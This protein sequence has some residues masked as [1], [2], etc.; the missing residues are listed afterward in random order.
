MDYL[1]E[2]EEIVGQLRKARQPED[3]FGELKG[4]TEEMLAQG[5]RIYRKMAQQVHPDTRPGIGDDDLANEGFALL[6]KLWGVAQI[7]IQAGMYGR[8]GEP[9]VITTRKRE[10]TVLDVLEKGDLC[11]LY[12]CTFPV[13][14]HKVKGVFKVARESSDNDLVNNEAD[15][16]KYLF[17]ADSERKFGAYLPHLIETFHYRDSDMSGSRVVNVLAYDDEISSP[18]ALYS[19]KQVRQHCRDGIDPRDMAWMWRRT[20][21]VL[22]FAHQQQV[23]H[24]AVLPTHI[25][26]QPE[27]HGL[28]LI[29]WAY[30][31]QDPQ[32]TGRHIR[33]IS[34]EYEGWYPKEVWDKAAPMP[35]LDLFMAAKT[36]V[37]LLGGDP[38]NGT[39][40]DTVP[41]KLKKYFEWCM[42]PA[43]R[44]RP[45]KSW[46][47]LEEFDGMLEALWGPR[48][49]REFVM[50]KL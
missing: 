4:T 9:V 36:M 13:D 38:L 5:K 34:A 28:V 45:Q 23:I 18:S 46:Q 25:L 19:L 12:N 11:T 1:A 3:I 31:V 20:L 33:A 48:R 10:Y 50:P 17:K 6:N 14:G 29:D 15:V 42:Q 44:M 2:L 47:L 24:G 27:L 26:I 30:A 32:T 7:K 37:Y 41:A 49:F 8:A 43:V 39:M 22:G 16:L 35:G 21:M 40:P